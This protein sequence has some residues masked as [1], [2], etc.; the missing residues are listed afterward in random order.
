MITCDDDDLSCEPAIKLGLSF[1][2]RL[3]IERVAGLD[4]RIA[5]HDLDGFLAA[6]ASNFSAAMVV[7]RKV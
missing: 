3:R 2:N 4:V 6:I 7:R 1:T 5:P